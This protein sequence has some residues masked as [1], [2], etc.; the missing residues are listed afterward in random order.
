[1]LWLNLLLSIPLLSYYSHLVES[2]DQTLENKVLMTVIFPDGTLP[3]SINGGFG[4]QTTFAE[5]VKNRD[6]SQYQAELHSRPTKLHLEDYKGLNIIRAFPLQFPFG[7]SGLPADANSWTYMKTLKHFLR[8]SLPAMHHGDFILVI[9]NIYARSIA[10]RNAMLRCQDTYKDT[11]YGE[12]FANISLDGISRGVTQI[13]SGQRGGAPQGGHVVNRYF[14]SLEAACSSMAHTNGASRVARQHM[15]S[16]TMK[17]GL[18]AV[19]F[20][21][22]PD[23]EMSFRIRVHATHKWVRS[24]RKDNWSQLYILPTICAS[25]FCSNLRHSQEKLPNMEMDDTE[26]LADFKL[27][28]SFRA[29]H[30]GLCAEEYGK[31]LHLVIKHLVG[32][33]TETRESRVGGGI[34]GETEA[35]AAATEEQSRKTLHMHILVWIKNW[36]GLLTTILQGNIGSRRKREKYKKA[37]SLMLSFV[38]NA[39]CSTIHQDNNRDVLDADQFAHAC[40]TRTKKRCMMGVEEQTLR[41]MRHKTGHKECD[42]CIARCPKC[43]TGLTSEALVLNVLNNTSTRTFAKFPDRKTQTLSPLISNH[44][45]DFQWVSMD[46]SSQARRLFHYNAS[47]NLHRTGHAVRCFKRDKECFARLPKPPVEKTAI[48]QEEKSVDWFNC[49]GQKE[50]CYLFRVEQKRSIADAF[51]NTHNPMTTKILGCNNNVACALS[52][53]SVIYATAYTGKNTQKDDR[54]AYERVCEAMVRQLRAQARRELQEPDESLHLPRDYRMGL[55]RLLS[56][57]MAHTHAHIVSAPMARHIIMSEERFEYSHEYAKVPVHG[58]KGLLF[59]RKVAFFMRRSQGR[60]IPFTYALNYVKRPAAME[61]MSVYDFYMNTRVTTLKMAQNEKIEY[62]AF[63]NNHPMH[64]ID[65]VVYRDKPCVPSFSYG[66]IPDASGLGGPI[67]RRSRCHGHIILSRSQQHVTVEQREY[68]ENFA[69]H[70]LILFYP[71]RK[72]ADLYRNNSAMEKLEFAMNSG[73]ISDGSILIADNIQN[74]H[75]SLNAGV[76]EEGLD[77]RTSH[78]DG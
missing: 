78:F 72:S 12:A 11:T 27:R 5:A 68:R 43:H 38:K 34:F 48:E 59:E 13:R 69:L 28:A 25:L 8:L 23:D 51:V 73:K 66:F 60:N 10:F 56:G 52:G 49:F 40:G 67:A 36:N 30:P 21:V 9:H 7:L 39:A 70:F 75:N 3:E 46:A 4:N 14:T 54:Y 64:D 71:A 77:S 53:R 18:P 16:L 6:L 1:L 17:F 61:D 24:L 22:T 45:M 33:D 55:R 37:V 76:P 42:G 50:E 57:I 63:Q 62:W 32:W 65:V 35:F 29:V 58:I 26:I 47:Y 19:F 2:G 41:K 44:L 74:I 31:C 15:F 20:T